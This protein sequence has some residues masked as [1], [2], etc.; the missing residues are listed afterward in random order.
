MTIAKPGNGR[1]FLLRLPAD[2]RKRLEIA[3]SHNGN[4]LTAEILDRVEVTLEI[5]DLSAVLAEVTKSVT[6][7]KKFSL[8]GKN[9]VSRAYNRFRAREKEALREFILEVS[10]V[11]ANVD[12]SSDDK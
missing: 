6:A 5:Q 2:L 11:V 3:R 1:S 12:E 4:S 8:E 7:S 10:L 9:T